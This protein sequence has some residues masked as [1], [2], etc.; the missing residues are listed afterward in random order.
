[1]TQS[2]ERAI[3]QDTIA[4][5]RGLDGKQIGGL[6]VIGRKGDLFLTT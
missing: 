2:V 1:M 3:E 6:V 5:L 4:I